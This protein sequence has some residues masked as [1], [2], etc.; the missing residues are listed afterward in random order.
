MKC[1]RC[2][3]R[4]WNAGA[5]RWPAARGER[6]ETHLRLLCA[7]TEAPNGLKAAREVTMSIFSQM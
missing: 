7:S 4:T 1:R 5:L 6:H 3:R 2:G